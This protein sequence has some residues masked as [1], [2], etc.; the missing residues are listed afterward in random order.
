MVLRH[1]YAF[2][3]NAGWPPADVVGE[4]SIRVSQGQDRLPRQ[5]QARRRDTGQPAQHL[6]NL[7][8]RQVL[9]PQN[10]ALAD[11]SALH[12]AKVADRYVVDVD[13]VHSRLDIG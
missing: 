11:S 12:R 2:H 5:F 6:E 7:A 9:M 3:W 8:K 1:P 10:I 4:P 13:Q